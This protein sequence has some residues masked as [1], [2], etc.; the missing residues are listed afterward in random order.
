MSE[1]RQLYFNAI[2]LNLSL[3]NIR[4]A[5]ACVYHFP[6]EVGDSQAR[7]MHN[8]TGSMHTA[9]TINQVH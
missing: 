7:G 5:F 6:Q 4:D 2:L 9:K 3:S 8:D 1:A